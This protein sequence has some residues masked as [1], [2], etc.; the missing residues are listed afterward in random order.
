MREMHELIEL[1]TQWYSD[2]QKLET[3]RLIQL[4]SLGS[5]VVKVL[6]I[7]DRMM[8]LPRGNQKSAREN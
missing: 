1:M 7:K 4:L 5:K 6:D 8:G 2:V 3:E